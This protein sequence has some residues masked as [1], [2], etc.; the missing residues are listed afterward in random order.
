MIE[1]ITYII[2]EKDKEINMI[3]AGIIGSTGYAGQELVRILTQHKMCIRD[4]LCH[5]SEKKRKNTQRRHITCCIHRTIILFHV[6][7]HQSRT[8]VSENARHFFNG[9]KQSDCNENYLRIH[10][11][12]RPDYVV[13][14]E[15]NPF[16]WR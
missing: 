5:L 2:K 3:K 13:D 10:N 4:S 8:H 16:S 11:L 14:H 15:S 7:V 12:Q 9:P 6:Y 1:K